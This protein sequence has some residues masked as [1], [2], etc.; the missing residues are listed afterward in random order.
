MLR[1]GLIW[2]SK[3]DW[4]ER[5]ARAGGVERLLVRRFVAGDTRHDALGVAQRLSQDDGEL[6]GANAKFSFLGEEVTDPAD[7]EQAVSEYCALAM[8]IGDTAELN[9]RMGVKPTLLGLGISYETAERGLLTIVETASQNGVRVELDM[10]V[11]HTVDATLRLYRS[12]AAESELTGVALQSYLRRTPDDAQA[13]I[14]EGIARVRLTKG[15]YSESSR[16]AHSGAGP[17]RRAYTGILE[18]LWQAG[19]D[20]GVAT[21]DPVL[22]A[23]A[24]RLANDEPTIGY[25]EFQMLYGVR[26]ELGAAMRA[27]GERLRMSIPYGARWYPYLMRRIAERPSNA[28]FALR[29]IVGR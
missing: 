23:A 8:A 29:A 9:A 4:A 6:L 27:R 14:D 11:S 3:Q 13:L 5:A 20:V 22:H 15:A 18:Q 28:L 24:R 17:I 10:E 12:A 21:H 26:P 1:P 2:L 19:A 7:A 25:W 16:I